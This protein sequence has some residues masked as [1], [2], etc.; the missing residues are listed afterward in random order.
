MEFSKDIF[1]ERI[2]CQRLLKGLTQKGLAD[3]LHLNS[4]S[5]ITN[6]ETGLRLPEIEM[7]FKL[8]D[9]FG[10]TT[11]YLLGRTTDVRKVSKQDE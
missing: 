10:V 6:W 4:A 1:A 9:C 5:T 7:L 8:A 2:K 11:D 3:M